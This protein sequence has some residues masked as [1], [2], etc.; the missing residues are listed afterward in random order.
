MM[1]TL[2]KSMDLYLEPRQA[3]VR[4]GSKAEELALSICCPFMA[5]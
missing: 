4:Y 1:I 5:V 2:I 3:H